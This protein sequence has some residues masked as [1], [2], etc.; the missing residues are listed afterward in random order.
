[1]NIKGMDITKNIRIVERLKSDLL[2][3]V[4]QL[5]GAMT[6]EACED[7]RGIALDTLSD[8]IIVC[9][10][11]GR[12][13]G[14]DYSTIDRQVSTK[15]RLGLIQGHDSE[16]FFG[17]LSALSRVRNNTYKTDIKG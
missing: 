16:K 6:D 2:R 8:S 12:R 11:L 17:D 9:Y 3:A 1:M 7:L 13:L 15:I 14:L 5:Y 10:L 4:S